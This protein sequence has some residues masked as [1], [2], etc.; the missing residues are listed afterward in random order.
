MAS[1]REKLEALRQAVRWGMPCFEL[2][3]GD[4]C[5]SRT[6][7]QAAEPA[8][9]PEAYP[10]PAVVVLRISASA[11]ELPSLEHVPGQPGYLHVLATALGATA[12]QIVP[13]AYKG[14]V[15]ASERSH[16]HEHEHEHGMHMHMACTCT[17]QRAVPGTEPVHMRMHMP[18]P[19]PPH[20]HAYA[21]ARSAPRHARARGGCGGG[22]GVGRGGGGTLPP[23]VEHTRGGGQRRGGIQWRHGC[24]AAGRSAHR[25]VGQASG[26]REEG[27]HLP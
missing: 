15:A 12:V 11:G 4:T 10:S 2:A 24:C 16:E 20:A 7:R 3:R 21:Q 23:G 17:S 19:C 6:G 8:P 13:L 22:G 18:T 14:Q 25:L 5:V 1:G 9:G 27:H 26:W